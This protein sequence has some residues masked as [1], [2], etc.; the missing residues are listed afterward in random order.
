[1]DMANFWKEL[2]RPFFVLAP[3]ED[4]T[5]TVFRQIVASVAKPDVFFTEFANVDAICHTTSLPP[6]NLGGG[7]KGGGIHPGLQR[8]IYSESERPIVAQVWGT[9]PEKFYKAAKLIKRLKFD[10]IDINL[11]CPVRKIIK[12]GACAALIGQNELV[13]EIIAAVTQAGL[14][15]SV[16]TRIGIKEPITEDW[17]DFL[18]TQNLAAITIHGRTATEKSE[19]PAKWDEIGKAVSLRNQSKSNTLIIGNGDV[20][21]I[22]NGKLKIE[23][24]GV[25][26]VMIGRGIF[27]NIGI[28]N[29]RCPMFNKNQKIKL[30]IKHI[31]LFEQT[32]ENTKNFAILKKFAKTYVNGYVG[33][34]ETREKLAATKSYDQLLDVLHQL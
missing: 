13:E 16:K 12:T 3:M 26:G 19:V 25:D 8:L 31:K 24:Y 18:L 20:D 7:I 6:P 34:A 33:A 23:N 22:E 14:P 9:D 5:D 4:V 2:K 21:S 30:F 10:G 27:Q 29:N 28:F 15:V 1:M 32:W 11:G 17:I